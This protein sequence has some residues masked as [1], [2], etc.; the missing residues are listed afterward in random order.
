MQWERAVSLDVRST[1]IAIASVQAS[2]G[3][4]PHWPGHH[5]D[6]WN[7]VEAVMALDVAGL[8]DEAKRGYRWLA[9]TQRSDGAWASAYMGDL[10]TDPTLDAN[11]CAYIATGMWHHYLV[12]GNTDLVDEMWPVIDRAIDFVLGLQTSDGHILWARDERYR[13]WPRPLL[14]SS[15]CIYLSLRCAIALSEVVAEERPDWELGL[16]CLH[17]AVVDKEDA[18]QDK[19]RFSMDWYYPVLTGAITGAAAVQRI[20]SRWDEFVIEGKGCRCVSDRPWVTT[21]ETA[22]LALALDAAG[23]DD[24]AATMLD[25]VGHLRDDDGAYWIGATQPDGTVWPRHKPTWGSGSVVLAAD[26][27]HRL[28]PAGDLFRGETFST[29]YSSF[30]S[31]RRLPAAAI[32]SNDPEANASR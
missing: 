19:D 13:P 2:D 30:S 1:A 22:E 28:T 15:A 26:A 9:S 27:V 21:G 29:A 20:E 32:S 25:W 4:I 18:F 12:T 8:H 3:S 16:E 7:H 10:I 14:T 23:L 31:T 6:P 17:E 24:E 5:A 11:F